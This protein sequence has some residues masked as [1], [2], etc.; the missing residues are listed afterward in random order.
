[1]AFQLGLLAPARSPPHSDHLWPVEGRVLTQTNSRD[2]FQKITVIQ[3]RSLPTSL[4]DRIFAGR[5][6][7]VISSLIRAIN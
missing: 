6:A 1:M 5:A 7:R 2:G 4:V 3:R